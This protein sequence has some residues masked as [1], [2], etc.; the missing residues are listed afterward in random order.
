MGVQGYA[1]SCAA[2]FIAVVNLLV[3][4]ISLFDYKGSHAG[5]KNSYLPLVRI[6]IR[7]DKK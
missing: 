3:N 4:S 1:L 5:E 7:D 6:Y 2:L